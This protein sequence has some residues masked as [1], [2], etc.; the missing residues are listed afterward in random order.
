MCPVLVSGA[1][2]RLL[3][4]G[5]PGGLWQGPWD[6]VQ[7]SHFKH[8]VFLP[9]RPH[10]KQ[11]QGLVDSAHLMP[12][13]PGGP[14]LCFALRHLEMAGRCCRE[15]TGLQPRLCASLG[16]GSMCGLGALVVGGGGGGAW[17]QG[18]RRRTQPAP[19]E[20]ASQNSC[21]EAAWAGPGAHLLQPRSSLPWAMW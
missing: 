8:R 5:V 18:E 2:S 20:E 13:L 1:Q 7:A 6:A 16:L 21:T 9:T 4:L 19:L 15:E 17:K 12:R 14:N 10:P 3:D 11:P